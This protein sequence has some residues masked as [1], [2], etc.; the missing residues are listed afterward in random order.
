MAGD[1]IKMRSDLQRHPKVVRMASALHADRLRTIGGLH[2][3]WSLFDEHSENGE[4]DG[5][6]TAAIDDLIG[7][8]G[9][10]DAM[11]GVAWLEVS[12]DYCSLPRFDEHNGQSAKRRAMESQ[13]KRLE[14]EAQ[15]VP[16]PSASNA[17]GKRSREEKR[18]EEKKEGDKK[19]P[20]PSRKPRVKP[21]LVTIEDLIAEGVNPTHAES[22]L[23]VRKEKGLPLTK[24]AWD[25]IKDQ[26]SG[27]GLPPAEAVRIAAENSWGGFKATWYQNQLAGGSGHQPGARA[28]TPPNRQAALEQRNAAVGAAWAAKRTDP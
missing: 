2:A 20:T 11:V 17:D 19:P 14:R 22:W 4:I 23:L 1:W 10:S 8:P 28:A 3:V 12:E 25:G 6:T 9:F 5:Y 24:T 27:V 26:A 15:D 18:R 7:W 21:G 16:V 13:R